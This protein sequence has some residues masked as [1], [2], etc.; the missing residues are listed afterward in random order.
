MLLDSP[1]P[2]RVFR[3]VEPGAPLDERIWYPRSA[4]KREYTYA[5]PAAGDDGLQVGGLDGTSLDPVRLREMGAASVAGRYPH[6]HSVLIAHR[7][8]LV[9]EE[10]F[11]EYDVTTRHALRSATKS[12]VSALVGLAIAQ[13]RLKEVRQRVLPFFADEHPQ[14]AHLTQRG[15]ADR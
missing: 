3:R 4:S 5:P 9:F 6:V 8:R 7:G 14:L 12:V 2:A 1:D 13:G 10:Y 15:I 11:Y